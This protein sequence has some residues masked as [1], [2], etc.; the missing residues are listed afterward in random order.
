MIL[1]CGFLV[2]GK[3]KLYLVTQRVDTSHELLIVKVLLLLRPELRIGNGK[4]GKNSYFESIYRAGGR[5]DLSHLRV[6]ISGQFLQIC[7]VAY[8]F[9]CIVPTVNFYST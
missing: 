5:Y 6:D 1:A 7:L 3:H 2:R 9:N 4:S 8:A